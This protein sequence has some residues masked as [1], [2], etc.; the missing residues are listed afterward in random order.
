MNVISLPMPTPWLEASI[1]I[2]II[3]AIGVACMRDVQRAAHWSL[4]LTLLSFVCTLIGAVGFFGVN[5][6][7]GNDTQSMQD[8]IAP[9]RILAFDDL[10]APLIPCVALL[11]FMTVLATPRTKMPRF[12]F[13]WLLAA[14]AVRLATFSC[15]DPWV[16]VL[17]LIAGTA[18]PLFELMNRGKPVRIYLLHM[19][20]CVALLLLGGIMM[21]ADLEIDRAWATVPLVLAILIRSGTA[22]AHVWLTDLFEN[23]TFGTALLIATPI[24]AVLATIRLVLPSAPDWVL[25]SVSVVSLATAAYAAGMAIVQRETRRFF[26]FLF[27]SHASLVLVGLELVTSISLTGALCLWFSVILSLSGLGLTLRA[28]EARFGRLPLTDY[29]GLYRHAPA[30]ALCFLITGLASVGFPGTLGF[31]SAELLV[32]GAIEA[33]LYVGIAVVLVGA[34]NGIAIVRAYF[35]LFTG[36]QHGATVPLNITLRERIAVLTLAALMVGGGLFPQPGVANRHAA[37]EAI[38]KDRIRASSHE[39]GH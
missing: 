33:N 27:L 28:L 31:V 26:A 11:H 24:V 20:L 3:G 30:L 13:A 21:Q 17:L 35:L 7:L 14:G 34:L 38:L 25:Q 6:G 10:N 36:T 2:C 29:Q 16:L 5:A 12:S 1:V 8:A 23:A 39:P 18:P 37:A 4:G 22:P 19:A 15:I 32:D 9:M